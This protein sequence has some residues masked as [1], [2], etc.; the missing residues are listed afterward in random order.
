MLVLDGGEKSNNTS[1]RYSADGSVA[2]V[3]EALLQQLATLRLC[4]GQPES[5]CIF[6]KKN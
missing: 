4:P 5:M 1:I 6:F 3:L 2:T